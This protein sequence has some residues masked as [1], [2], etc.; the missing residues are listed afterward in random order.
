[1]C[2]VLV[3]CVLCSLCVFTYVV[4]VH[5][6]VEGESAL[7]P[8]TYSAHA[9]TH[10]HNH[11]RP[12]YTAHLILPPTNHTLPPHTYRLLSSTASPL[13]SASPTTGHP[14]TRAAATSCMASRLITCTTYRGVLT[15]AARRTARAVASA[16]VHDQ[17]GDVGGI[18]GGM[19]G[20]MW[21]E[22]LEGMCGEMLEGMC[23][24]MLERM[25]GGMCGGMRPSNHHTLV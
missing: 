24:E 10:P 8:P 20:E 1:M 5:S 13:A 23:G 22:M 7:P 21:G 18:C 4:R 11:A 14:C 2:L 12:T 16:C 15:H 19:C 3:L 6:H 17:V 9:S 25:C